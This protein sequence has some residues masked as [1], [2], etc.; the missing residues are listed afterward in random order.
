MTNIYIKIKL[1]LKK[2]KFIKILKYFKCFEIL[3]E[4]FHEIF[5]NFKFHEIF[6]PYEYEFQ[7]RTSKQMVHVDALSKLPLNTG[8]NIEN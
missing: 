6:K 2:P 8:T 7:Y 3:H 4:I 1:I 5:H